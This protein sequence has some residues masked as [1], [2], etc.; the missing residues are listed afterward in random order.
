MV[1]LITLLGVSY[2]IGR[3]M[4]R[5]EDRLEKLEKNPIIVA[6]NKLSAKVLSDIL[7]EIFERKLKANPLTPDEINLRRQLT[8]K[9]D[10]GTITPDEARTLHDILNKELAEAQAAGNILAVLVIILLIGLIDALL[11]KGES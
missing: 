5:V 10:A 8:E 7:Y 2:K 4:Q 9:L 3:W 6:G 11:S 1:T